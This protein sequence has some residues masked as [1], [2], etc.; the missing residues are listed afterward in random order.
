MAGGIGVEE[1]RH[2]HTACWQHRMRRGPGIRRR[3]NP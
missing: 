3:L 1:R 2:W